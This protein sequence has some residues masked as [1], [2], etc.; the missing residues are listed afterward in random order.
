MANTHGGVV[1]TRWAIGIDPGLSICTA[2][3]LLKDDVPLAAIGVQGAR[4]ER[5][6]LVQRCR[7]LAFVVR[8][9]IVGCIQQHKIEELDVMI[10]VPFLRKKTPVDVMNV[11]GLMAAQ[12][13]HAALTMMLCDMANAHEDSTAIRY[14]PV[15]PNTAKAVFTGNGH[16]S[17]GGMIQHSAWQLRPDVRLREHLADAQAIGTCAPQMIDLSDPH[18]PTLEPAYHDAK[19]GSG[20]AWKG[21]WPP[22]GR[23]EV[24]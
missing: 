10:E 16:A 5:A 3:V 4:P 18:I 12:T 2:A 6:H 20:S 24:R 15:F 9:F 23:T 8:D 13:L 14:G 21:K 19:L 17:K 1:V 11:Q 7:A 22:G